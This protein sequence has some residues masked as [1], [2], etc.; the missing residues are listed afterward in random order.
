MFLILFATFPVFQLGMDGGPIDGV[1]GGVMVQS[2]AMYQVRLCHS[3][4]F[5]EITGIEVHI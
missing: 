5:K 3:I 1:R 2:D 4:K